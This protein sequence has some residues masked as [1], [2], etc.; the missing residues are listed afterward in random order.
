MSARW[1]SASLVVG[2]IWLVVGEG[3][4]AP[5][6]QGGDVLKRATDASRASAEAI[7]SGAGV[8]VFESYA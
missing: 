2:S 6:P 8:V 7:Q 4:T 5:L 1:I 3:T